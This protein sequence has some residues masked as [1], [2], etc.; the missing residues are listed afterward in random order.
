MTQCE[1]SIQALSNIQYNK[2]KSVHF[3]IT[4][5]TM[6]LKTLTLSQAFFGVTFKVGTGSLKRFGF[7][8]RC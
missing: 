7:P 4:K 2:T 3:N 1:R 5:L 8:F 6:A